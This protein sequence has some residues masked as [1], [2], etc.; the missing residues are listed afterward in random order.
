MR[1]LLIALL[2]MM[3]SI[4][5]GAKEPGSVPLDPQQSE[6]L[7]L[8]AEWMDY[9]V[10]D[11][12]L[13]W[14]DISS[15]STDEW[16][17]PRTD[18]VSRW[19]GENKTQWLRFQ[20]DNA[21]QQAGKFRLEVRWP[22]LH[23]VEMRVLREDGFGEP[24]QA[25]SKA[26]GK[27]ASKNIVFPFSLQEG[28]SATVY[29]RIVDSSFLYLPMY[30]WTE[31]AYD[32][33]LLIRLAIFCI[34][35]GVL[36]VMILYNASLYF[37]TRDSMYLVYSNS[38]LS[39]L[40]FL[41]AITG[42]GRFLVWGDQPWFVENA[43]PV[44][45]TYCFLSVTYF[46]RV[47]VDLKRHGGW[48]LKCN[49][50]ILYMWSLVLVGN[51]LGFQ[52]LAMAVAGLGGVVAT[53]V[54]MAIAWLLWMRGSQAA[55][56]FSIAW[57]PVCFATVYSILALLGIVKYF[58]GLDYMQTLSFVFEVVVLSVAL[59]D[60]INRER[61]ARE[62]AQALALESQS[63][64]VQLKE[65][66]N[67]KLENQVELRTRELQSA[68]SELAKANTDLAKL[69]KTDPLTK[70]ANRRLF[71]DMAEIEVSR[72]IRSGQP[73]SI[74][75]IDIDHFKAVNDSYGHI[76]GDNCLKLVATAIAEFAGRET[77]VVARYGGEEFAVIL[78]GTDRAHALLVAERIREAI[79]SIDVVY[80]GKAIAIT[81]SIGVVGA[82][83]PR[84]CN[85]EHL[86]NFA[87]KAL[88]AAKEKGRN[89]V[90]AGFVSMAESEQVEA[91]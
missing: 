6:G 44:F 53:I 76:A 15:Q 13:G 67:S 77:D 84:N 19:A 52:D 49:T 21:S 1:Y 33:H 16:S 46:F 54:S 55:K 81:A 91:L 88:Y 30:L 62:K 68:L 89:R 80:E 78:P 7:M 5:T 29:L 66:A 48:V 82:T 72:A 40:L 11:K 69:S 75:I 42:L 35:L 85:V 39:T 65:Q 87:D 24:R 17:K 63:A 70:L 51:L 14:G 43:Y 31:E 64:I 60:R 57:A 18:T 4:P 20:V 37:F 90:E 34:A 28:E 83:L 71:D 10:T 26:A 61:E 59:A 58:P 38:V 12:G 25:G 56:F 36:S 73:L 45:S 50:F 23:D 86:V 47:F 2:T 3:A 41:L 79:Q 22:F 74:M 9:R 8:T 32:R 27:G